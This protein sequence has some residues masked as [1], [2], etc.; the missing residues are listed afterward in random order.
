MPT[1]GV[2]K[3]LRTFIRENKKI[4]EDPENT[5]LKPCKDFTW[6]LEAGEDAVRSP[7]FH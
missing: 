7:G 6:N 1:I 4:P 5:G 3:K 2:E